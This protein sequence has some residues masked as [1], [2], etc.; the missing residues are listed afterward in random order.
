MSDPDRSELWAE[1]LDANAAD[2]LLSGEPDM[3]DELQHPEIG[4]FVTELRTVLR[5][6]PTPPRSR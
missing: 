3:L 5:S 2:R 4:A 1:P 6:T